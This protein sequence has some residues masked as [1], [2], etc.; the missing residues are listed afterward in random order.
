MDGDLT[1]WNMIQDEVE[2]LIEGA[3][4]HVLS[5]NAMRKLAMIVQEE[6]ADHAKRKVKQEGRHYA[7]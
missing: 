6:A 4:Q 5:V 3:K 7:Y 2:L 1:K